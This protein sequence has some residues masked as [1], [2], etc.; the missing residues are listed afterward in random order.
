MSVAQA[1]EMFTINGAYAVGAEGQIG[2][3]EEGK[4]AD[5]VVITQN[6]FEVPESEIAHTRAFMTISDAIVVSIWNEA[7]RPD[8][9]QRGYDR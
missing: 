8:G 5:M 4:I 9:R 1:I 7:L 3:I 6:L 2:S